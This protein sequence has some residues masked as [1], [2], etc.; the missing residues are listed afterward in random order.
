MSRLK[1]AAAF[2]CALILGCGAPD[3]PAG[4][5][6]DPAARSPGQWLVINYW[7]EWCKPCIEEIPHLN[8]FAGKHAGTARVLM[9]NF[10]GL[11]GEELRRQA[12]RLGI[13]TEVPEEDP[14]PGLG[15]ERP[16]A[17]PST[18]LIDPDG[19]LHTVLLGPQTLASLEAAMGPRPEGPQPAP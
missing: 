10:D 2:L 7:A 8:D 13:E 16:Q 19:R 11:R 9:V 4:K 14:G 6:P 3:Q 17:L 18:Y 12:G 5:S 15:L 1:Y